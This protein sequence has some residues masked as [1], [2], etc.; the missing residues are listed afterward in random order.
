VAGS[1]SALRA[2]GGRSGVGAPAPAAA[3]W[4]AS[5]AASRITSCSR[6][7]FSA[8]SG[9]NGIKKSAYPEV[10]GLAG[11]QALASRKVRYRNSRVRVNLLPDNRGWVSVQ[12]RGG[13]RLPDRPLARGRDARLTCRA[14][15]VPQSQVSDRRI[16]AGSPPVEAM[17]ASPTVS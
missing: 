15:S 2:G 4:S 5:S 6:A 9:V 7:R 1:G 13:V 8:S 16:S 11:A 17:T 10:L 14:I 3:A 12:R